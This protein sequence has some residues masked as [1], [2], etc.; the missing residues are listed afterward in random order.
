MASKFEGM[1]VV[2]N[3]KG[4]IVD[5][6]FGTIEHWDNKIRKY[7]VDFHNGFCGW[8]KRSELKPREKEKAD[9]V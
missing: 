8:F 9:E 5:G 1:D 7:K 4:N 2:I 3:M 6:A